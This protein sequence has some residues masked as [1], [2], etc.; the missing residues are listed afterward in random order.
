MAGLLIGLEYLAV[1]MHLDRTE[2]PDFYHTLASDPAFYALVDI[3]WDANFL[4]HAQTVHGKPLVG[5]WLA[6]LPERQAAYLDQPSLDKAFLYLLVG[7]EGVT[8]TDPAAIR[9]AV[10]A[11][12]AERQVRYIINHN[13]SAGLWLEPLTGWRVLY[14]QEGMVVYGQQAPGVK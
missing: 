4:M 12:L 9:Q 7:P 13:T 3:K 11:A 8:L 10:S 1:P 14:E 2:A 6:R 5:G